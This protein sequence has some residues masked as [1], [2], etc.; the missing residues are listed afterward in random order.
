MRCESVIHTRCLEAAD[1]TCP[2]CGAP[3]VD[4]SEVAVVVPACPVCNSP[5]STRKCTNCGHPTRWDSREDLQRH[6]AH[7]S[8]LK[9]DLLIAGSTKLLLG[10]AILLAQL[11][12]Y[13][14]WTIRG[15]WIAFTVSLWI[16]A[17]GL[18]QRGARQLRYVRNITSFTK[19]WSG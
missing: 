19:S 17:L 16:V 3:H 18:L 5:A 2:S 13:V 12:W 15:G 14:L 11:L 1:G 4:P 6:L 7:L 8:E 9:Q 10:A